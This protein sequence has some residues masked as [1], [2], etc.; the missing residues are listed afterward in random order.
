MQIDRL[1]TKKRYF[2]VK[3]EYIIYLIIWCCSLPKFV[4]LILFV[5]CA[6]YNVIAFHANLK[7]HLYNLSVKSTI[8]F[9]YVRLNK[10]NGYDPKTGIF[11][12]PEDGVYSFAWSFLSGRG[13][14]VYMATVVD[15]VDHVY[16]LTDTHQ[17]SSNTSYHLLCELEKGNKVWIR[18]WHI[19]AKFIH[20]GLYTYFSGNKLH[21][22]WTLS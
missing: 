22:I 9:D 21:S 19:P 16:T 11:T 20:R 14:T 17:T 12:A 8:K 1:G 7:T 18:I 6:T 3:L 10:G 13:S 15:N 4:I 5:D 2:D